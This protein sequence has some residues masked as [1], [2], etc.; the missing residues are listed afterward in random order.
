MENVVV[1]KR[2]ILEGATVIA[3]KRDIGM[4]DVA[5]V[6]QPLAELVTAETGI[7][8]EIVLRIKRPG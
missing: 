7:N 6:T 2:R 1:L 8:V 4:D 3:K 5:L